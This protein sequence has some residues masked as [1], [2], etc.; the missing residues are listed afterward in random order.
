MVSYTY[1]NFDLRLGWNNGQVT[2]SYT[3]PGKPALPP[4]VT[5]YNQDPII[6]ATHKLPLLT[7]EATVNGSEPEENLKKAGVEVAELLMPRQ[8]QI[9]QEF[10]NFKGQHERV[11]LR[12]FYP[13]DVKEM[14]ALL[15]IPWEYAFLE[16]LPAHEELYLG[17]NE[18]I[19]IAHCLLPQIDGGKLARNVESTI[20]MA[21]L[22]WLGDQQNNSPTANELNEA[23]QDFVEELKDTA[24]I[25]V[26]YHNNIPGNMLPPVEEQE[27]TRAFK[28]CHLVHLIGHGNAR[29]IE[30]KGGQLTS[31][32]LS[33]NFKGRAGFDQKVDYPKAVL[34][35]SCGSASQDP[36]SIAAALHRAGVPVVIGTTRWIDIA[37]ARDFVD[38]FYKAFFRPPDNSLEQ[39]LVSGRRGM[40]QEQGGNWYVGFGLPRLYL[41]SADSILIP[42]KSLYPGKAPLQCADAHFRKVLREATQLKKK[43]PIDETSLLQNIG[44]IKDWVKRKQGTLYYVSGLSGSGKSTQ[45]ARLKQE[46]EQDNLAPFFYHFCTPDCPG[47]G[48]RLDFVRSLI[49]QL[50]VYFKPKEYDRLCRHNTHIRFPLLVDNA[51]DALTTFIIRPLR[52]AKDEAQQKAAA[53]GQPAPPLPLIIIDG[54]DYIPNPDL[55]ILKLLIRHRDELGEVARFLITADRDTDADKAILRDL[56]QRLQP[57]LVITPSQALPIY[58]QMATR[59]KSCGYKLSVASESASVDALRDLYESSLNDLLSGD[60]PQSAQYRK[61]LQVLS[62]AYQPLDPSFVAKII[63]ESSPDIIGSKKI[64]PYVKSPTSSIASQ[65]AR[66]TKSLPQAA[67]PISPDIPL[68]LYHP[69]LYRFLKNQLLQTP[70]EI[71]DSHELF[72]QAF[73]PAKGWNVIKDWAALPQYAQLY[74]G[75]HAY[76]AYQNSKTVDEA[77]R[78]KRAK[79][80]LELICNSGFRS[81]Q[82]INLEENTAIQDIRRGLNVAFAEYVLLS[83]VATPD[84]LTAFDKLLSADDTVLADLERKL[85]RDNGGILALLTFLGLA[86]D[87]LSKV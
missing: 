33:A 74:L 31:L 70:A 39:A 48:N 7:N 9:R 87:C 79:T 17:L 29:S 40:R 86:P 55:S 12:L 85:R 68:T 47:T 65:P 77:K 35:I 6:S 41:C 38:G 69:S 51:D 24:P 63:P 30:L 64:W 72:V 8:G 57:D 84:A 36:Y 15:Q 71:A 67:D 16:E 43:E 53:S 2:V 46:L 26:D 32:E 21:Y 59:F 42:Q 66:K 18:N 23:F 60:E 19:S 4:E 27:V 37:P 5:L 20:K 61:L 45:I 56:T 1:R 13:N 81:L 54:L 22:S 78:R 76:E 25:V 49:F 58:V 44:Q 82:L 34:L 50:R 62:L 28:E 11:R 80:F 10:V 14:N 73:L 83:K 3:P 75:D 52:R